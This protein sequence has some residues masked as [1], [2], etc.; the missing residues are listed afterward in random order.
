MIYKPFS[1]IV[2]YQFQKRRKV[3]IVDPVAG[4]R[5][6]RTMRNMHARGQNLAVICKIDVEVAHSRATKWRQVRGTQR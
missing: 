3:D 5:G 6:R 1:S 2:L 4:H